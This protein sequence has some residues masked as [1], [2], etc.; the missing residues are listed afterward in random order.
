MIWTALGIAAALQLLAGVLRVRGWFHVIRHTCPNSTLRY[1]DVAVAHLG[2]CG[3]NAVLPARAGDAVKVALVRLRMPDT[4][5][6]T[7]GCT[8]VAPAAVDAALTAAL[9][10]ALV[11]AGALSVDTLASLVPRAP[12]VA[13]AVAVAGA[14][15]LLAAFSRHRV[16]RLARDARQGLSAM[17]QPRLIAFGV[18]PWQVL[19]R[20]VRLLSF[21]LVLVAAG[22]PFSVGAALALMALQ[23]TS[24]S[25]APAATAVRV[26]LLAGVLAGTGA[27]GAD[28][29]MLAATLVTAYVVTSVVNLTVSGTV[30]AA[31]LGTTSPRRVFGY[32]R[33]ALRPAAIGPEA[34][35]SRL[36]RLA[37]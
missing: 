13:V 7:L 15:V 26:A 37:K 1:R 4:P 19:S 14:C 16:R 3:L 11:A 24:P 34:T 5:L 25:V 33:D 31:V 32:V 12:S 9:V 27:G 10:A 22:L 20:V 6:A 2:G 28:P 17:R 30:I 23:G 21:A 29:A 35:T 36:V 18:V 8:L